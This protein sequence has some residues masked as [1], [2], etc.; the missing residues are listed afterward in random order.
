MDLVDEMMWEDSDKVEFIS[1]EQ[2]GLENSDKD[3]IGRI[4][5]DNYFQGEM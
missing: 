1:L 3:T 5:S 4:L 2:A